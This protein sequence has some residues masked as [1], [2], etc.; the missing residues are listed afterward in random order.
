[1]LSAK[2]RCSHFIT[3]DGD[4]QGGQGVSLG[5]T[6]VTHDASGTG[7]TLEAPRHLLG[8]PLGLAQG[9]GSGRRGGAGFR[10]GAAGASLPQDREWRIPRWP[11]LSIST[12]AGAAPVLPRPLPPAPLVPARKLP[13]P[14]P[15]PHACHLHTGP[16][17]PPFGGSGPGC[18]GLWE[19][20][21]PARG[22]S[23]R[24]VVA[25]EASKRRSLYETQGTRE[26]KEPEALSYTLRPQ[27][28][29]S[30]PAQFTRP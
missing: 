27:P 19:A 6:A 12:A 30:L 22:A 2:G 8:Q 3:E 7:A 23:P 29:L 20:R 26:T 13:C 10:Q 18:L 11:Q 4:G 16:L 17:A 14:S 9:Q 15:E 25:T 1:M 28:P 5:H 21:G 24:S